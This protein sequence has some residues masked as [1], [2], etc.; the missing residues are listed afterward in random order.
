MQASSTFI[1]TNTLRQSYNENEKPLQWKSEDFNPGSAMTPL[2]DLGSSF[3]LSGT[4]LSSSENAG[5]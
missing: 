2:N 5:L 4:E 3:N 1:E